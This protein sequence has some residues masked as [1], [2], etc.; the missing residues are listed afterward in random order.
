MDQTA[1]H[2]LG[3]P[4]ELLMENAGTAVAQA[5]QDEFGIQGKRFLFIC[6]IGNNGGDG[7]VAARK[8]HS[9]GGEVVVGIVGDPDRCRGSAKMNFEII[10]RLSLTLVMLDTIDALH[11][12]LAESDVIIDALIGTGL[13]RPV[14]SLHRKLIE[15]INASGKAVLSVDIPSGIHG[16]SGQIMG[17]A[18]QA[19]LTVTFGLPKPGN[20]LP[21]GC[22]HCGKLYV[23]HISFPPNLHQSDECKTQTNWPLPRDIHSRLSQTTASITALMHPG[24]MAQGHTPLAFAHAFLRSG[25]TQVKLAYAN[26]QRTSMGK[27]QDKIQFPPLHDPS[28]DA[29]DMLAWATPVDLVLLGPNLPDAHKFK[30]LS[31]QMLQKLEH[32]LLLDG[33]AIALARDHQEEIRKRS[34][35]TI[36]TPS[37]N[38]LGRFFGMSTSDILAS[39]LDHVR[40]MASTLKAFVVLKGTPIIICS[41]NG[42]VWINKHTAEAEANDAAYQWMPVILA[43]HLDPGIPIEHS[44]RLGAFVFSVALDHAQGGKSPK[45]AKSDEILENIPKVLQ[46]LGGERNQIHLERYEAAMVI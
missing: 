42:D 32:P 5:L 21:P 31:G 29:Y 4:A 37:L 25:G 23:S 40:Q 13:S 26:A 7:M 34:S 43:A 39:L 41:P 8:L 9:N 11:G 12:L 14:R 45:Q 30:P 36:L 33:E 35:A 6:G 19:D 1:I 20:M 38:D 15:T 18:I 24:T 44:V 17:A 3:I 16:D 10:T 27:D 2:Q 46:A 28:L 22:N